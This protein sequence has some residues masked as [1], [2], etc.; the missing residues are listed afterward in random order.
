MQ[1]MKGWTSLLIRRPF[2][3]ILLLVIGCARSDAATT[4]AEFAFLPIYPG[5]TEVTYLPIPKNNRDPQVIYT[6]PAAESAVRQFYVD[7]LTSAGWHYGYVTERGQYTFTKE[8]TP[9]PGYMYTSYR[10][11]ILYE[12]VG[13]TETNVSVRQVLQLGNP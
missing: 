1:R 10:L 13:P 12:E 11:E 5:V 6:A 3:L 2:L 9:R 7:A 8:M 4:Q